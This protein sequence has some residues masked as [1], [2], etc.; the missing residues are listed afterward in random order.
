MGVIQGREQLRF[1]AKAQETVTVVRNGVGQDLQR[2]VA[3]EVRVSRP[4]HLA[5]AAGPQQ[6]DD[7]VDAEARARTE[8]HGPRL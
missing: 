7:L 2:D 5:H 8:R 6:A 1:A 4:V 3:A